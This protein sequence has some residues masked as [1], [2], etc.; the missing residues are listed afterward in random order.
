MSTNS[1]DRLSLLT[2]PELFRQKKNLR[3]EAEGFLKW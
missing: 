1:D 3:F 2:Y